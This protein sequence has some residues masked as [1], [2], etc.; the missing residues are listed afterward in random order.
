M[1]KIDDGG[2]LTKGFRTEIIESPDGNFCPGDIN[3]PGITRRDWLA[4]LAM[5]GMFASSPIEWNDEQRAEAFVA[6]PEL[7]YV[8]ADAMIKKSKEVDK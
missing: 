4:G 7:S 5:Q 8:M 6:M 2:Y 3:Y 1:S